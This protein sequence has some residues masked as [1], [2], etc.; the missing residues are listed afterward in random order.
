MTRGKYMSIDRTGKTYCF[1]VCFDCE[2]TCCKDANP[3]LTAKRKQILQEYLD[4]QKISNIG[5]FVDSDYSHPST[6]SSGICAFYDKGTKRCGIHA[7][8]PETC[9]A[10]PITFDINLKTGKVEFYLKKASIC[11]F[12]GILYQNKASLTSHLDAAKLEITRF[13]LEAEPQTLKAILAIPEPETFKVDE[14]ELPQEVVEKLR[15]LSK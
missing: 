6:D 12:A 14:N 11:A 4:Q 3:P 10:G 1:D 2:V 13:I 8:K 7:V 15:I 5:V 9:K